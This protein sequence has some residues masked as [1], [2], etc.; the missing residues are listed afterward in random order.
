VTAL[1]SISRAT[2]CYGN[3][4][5][6]DQIDLD[7]PEG[8]RHALI[9]PNGAGKTTLLHLIAGTIRPTS[10]RIRFAGR[11]ITRLDPARRARLGIARTFQTPA[12]CA[13]L[14]ALD[15][16]VLGGWTRATGRRAAWWPARYRQLAARGRELLD[17]LGLADLAGQPAGSLSHG[18]RR[19]LEIGTALA[20][21]PRLL[22][23]DEPAAGLT[24]ADLPRLVACL[25]HL[26]APVA[27]LLVE[28]HLDLVTEVA[29][30]VTVLHHGR[31]LVTGPPGQVMAAPAVADLYLGRNPG[32]DPAHDP[33][34]RPEAG[35]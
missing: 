27:V 3:L 13:S 10:G 30:T 17:R 9:G 34:R 20:A 7:L 1:L 15:N 11:D 29:G 8:A 28:H 35:R 14:S 18:Q 21:R 22:L 26:P 24:A 32:R 23:L 4:T 5:A 2:R 16:L 33:G 31:H 25:R 6:L 19:L 12:V